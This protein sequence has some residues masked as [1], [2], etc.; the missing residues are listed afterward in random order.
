MIPPLAAYVHAKYF[1]FSNITLY[2]HHGS[3]TS[4]RYRKATN[5][6]KT[7][8]WE[9]YSRKTLPLTEHTVC[10]Q[11]AP[12]LEQDRQRDSNY[13]TIFQLAALNKLGKFNISM[14]T[15][16]WTDQT[17]LSFFS[18]FILTGFIRNIRPLSSKANFT[19]L[20]TEWLILILI[21]FPL[22]HLVICC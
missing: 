1:R 7:S 20:F 6:E 15:N 9:S 12:S 18:T 2:S 22:I 13:P 17:A 14:C 16:L 11:V 10:R 21:L 3:F 5:G 19:F 4:T 8:C